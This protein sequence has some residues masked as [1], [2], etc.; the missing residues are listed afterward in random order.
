[1]IDFVKINWS[2]KNCLETHL[3]DPENFDE[4]DSLW[5]KRC[6]KTNLDGYPIFGKTHNMDVKAFE[7]SA[8]VKNSIHKMFNSL[9]NDDSANYTDF[10]YSNLLESI[11]FLEEKLPCVDETWLSSLEFGLNLRV[12]E[13]AEKIISHTIRMHRFKDNKTLHKFKGKGFFYQFEYND[14]LIKVYDKAK[15]YGLPYH[16]LRVEVKYRNSKLLRKLRVNQL[17]DLKQKCILSNL[18]EDF[19]RR[20]NALLIVDKVDWNQIDKCDEVKLKTFLNP[21][22]WE[23]ELQGKSHTTRKRKRDE[24]YTLLDKY[25]LD[26]TKYRIMELLDSKFHQLINS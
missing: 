4:F 2:N 20:I 6:L 11:Q 21:Y 17:S 5:I 10:S 25:N 22:Y 9:T 8:S 26:T 14:Y 15:Q 13:K 23:N 1:M 3:N 18:Y 7:K 19:K 16:L 24:L 12:D